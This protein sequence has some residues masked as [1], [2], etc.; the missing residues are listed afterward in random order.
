MEFLNYNVPRR[1]ETKH[2]MLETLS[3]SDI[4]TYPDNREKQQHPRKHFFLNR[5]S[6]KPD[7]MDG[8]QKRTDLTRQITFGTLE[9][10]LSKA[11]K[12]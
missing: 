6:V 11:A 4:H 7:N 1:A 2:W 9:S 8:A 10:G 5:L 3:L 12:E